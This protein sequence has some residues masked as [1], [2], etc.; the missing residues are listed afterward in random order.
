MKLAILGGSF[1]PVHMGHLYLADTVL[2]A[3]AYDR[4][5]LV[6]AFESPF[7]PGAPGASPRDRLDMLAAS[8]TGDPR[9]TVDPC[10][11]NRRGVSYTIDTVRDIIGRYRPGGKP[12]LIIGDDLAGDFPQ[13]KE[14]GE[15]ARLADIIIA[16]R[17]LSGEASYPYPARQIRNAVM[18]LSSLRV[19]EAIREGKGWRYL[20]PAGARIIIEDRRLYDLPD[21]APAEPAAPTEPAPAR[22]FSQALLARLEQAVREN[23]SPSR[24]LH[25][26]NTA[27]LCWDL[28][29]R[30]GLDPWSGYLAGISHDMAKPMDDEELLRTAQRDGWAISELERRK[31]MLLHGRAAAVLLRERFG[32]HNGEVLEAVAFHTEGKA[33]MGALAKL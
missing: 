30:F 9:Q 33:G 8:I 21:T 1:N 10:E 19:R 16:R 23:L 6:P 18:D 28:C 20:V 2:S 15:I 31:P 3:F 32:V 5:I 27:L 22:E 13:W 12:G 25:S 4:I 26:R 11:I 7:K 17:I 14:A 24:F 29:R